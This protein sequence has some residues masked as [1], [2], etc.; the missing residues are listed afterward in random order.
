MTDTIDKMRRTPLPGVI[1]EQW[2]HST[3]WPGF[4]VYLDAPSHGFDGDP[5]ENYIECEDYASAQA[6]ADILAKAT[7]WPI[8]TSAK[9]RT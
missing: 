1:I 3:G 4:R 5:L 6:T 2:T 9:P 7:G 8:Y